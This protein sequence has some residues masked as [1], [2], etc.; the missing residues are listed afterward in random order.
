MDL[1]IAKYENSISA[2][3]ISAEGISGEDKKEGRWWVYQYLLKKRS[4]VI[5][6]S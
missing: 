6:F 5:I 4:E 1:M 2:E 3:G